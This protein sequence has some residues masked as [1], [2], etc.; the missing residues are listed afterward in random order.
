MSSEVIAPGEQGEIEARFNTKN[1]LGKYHK[2][3]SIYS[4][5]SLARIRKVFITAEVV[6]NL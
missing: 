4:N 2:A 6:K 1:R 3:I 5:D